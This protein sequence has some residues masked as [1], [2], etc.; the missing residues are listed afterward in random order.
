MSPDTPIACSLSADEL[1][2]RLAEIRAIGKDALVSV[3]P[4]GTLRFRAG[5]S[6]RRRLEAI[7]AAESQCCAFLG[8]ELN[9]DEGELALTIVAPDGAEPIAADLVDAFAAEAKAA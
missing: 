8:F 2:Q 3:R 5:E 7:I 1:P 9:A 4:D 6:T